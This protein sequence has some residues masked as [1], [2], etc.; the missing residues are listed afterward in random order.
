MKTIDL[1]SGGI[2]AISISWSDFPFVSNT[3]FFTKNTATRQKLPK[4]VYKTKGPICSSKR[5]NKR[6]TKKFITC[7]K[8]LT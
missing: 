6:P 2:S 1:Y 4:T 8:D 5:K 7:Y 3:F